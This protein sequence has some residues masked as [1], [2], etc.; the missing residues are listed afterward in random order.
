MLYRMEDLPKIGQVVRMDDELDPLIND[1]EAITCTA[2]LNDTEFDNIKYALFTSS[3][4]EKNIYNEQGVTYAVMRGY[5]D[6]E[7]KAC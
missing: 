1:G 3:N 6:M 7:G 2:I 5:I 4:P